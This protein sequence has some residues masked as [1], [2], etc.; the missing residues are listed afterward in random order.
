[1]SNQAIVKLTVGAA[2]DEAKVKFLQALEQS[3][4]FSHLQLVTVRAPQQE[5]GDQ[6][7]LE[8]TVIYSRA[9]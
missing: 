8:L 6:V 7:V 1:V 3:S 9:W 4:V 2:S 5:T